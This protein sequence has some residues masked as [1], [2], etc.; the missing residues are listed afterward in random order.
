[1]FYINFKSASPTEVNTVSVNCLQKDLHIF[2]WWL[3]K[4]STILS[5]YHSN[6][7]INF[8]YSSAVL[9]SWQFFEFIRFWDQSTMESH[10]AALK[11]KVI[12]FHY[13]H[14]HNYTF[15]KVFRKTHA[16]FWIY[17]NCQP[18]CQYKTSFNVD[19]ICLNNKIVEDKIG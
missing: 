15:Y 16:V 5:S 14:D 12:K 9:Y 11:A 3:N 1:M 4:V 17:F 2:R 19:K 7:S 13:Y 6:V 10:S 18:R 8:S